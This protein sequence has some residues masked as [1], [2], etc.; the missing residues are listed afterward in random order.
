MH[1]V[2]RR[3]FD[4]RHARQESAAS[5][6]LP[7]IILPMKTPLMQRVVCLL[8]IYVLL[9]PQVWATCG[10]GGGGGMGGMGGGAGTQTYPVPWKVVQPTDA[11][12][13]SGVAVY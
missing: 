6:S 4:K 11:P 1:F 3:L 12:I 9:V 5:G 2:P 8:M 7:A 13:K 10:G